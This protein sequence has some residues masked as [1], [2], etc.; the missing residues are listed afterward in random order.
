MTTQETIKLFERYVIANYARSPIVA[1]RGE[2]SYLWDAEGERYLD[3]FP[4]WGVNGIGHCHPRVVA[5]IR[6]Q[7]GKLLHVANVPFYIEQQGR[8][9]QLISERSFGGQCFFCN[10][11]AEANEAAI[12]LARR[13]ASDQVAKTGGPA[14]FKIITV[15]N[16]FHGRT[17]TTVA[18]TAQAKYHAGFYPLPPGFVHVPFD[19]VDVVAKVCDGETCAVLVE[20]IQGEGGV[21]IPSDDYLPRLREL[22]DARGILLILDEV[23]TGVGRTGKWFGHQHAGVEPDIMTLAKALGGGL[24]IGAMTARP[25]VARSLVPG[26]HA[27]T[28]G[29]NP[30]ACAAGIATFEAIEE[31]DLLANAQRIGEQVKS[32]MLALAEKLGLIREVRARGCMI[33]V[34]LDRPGAD[35]VARCTEN[36][37]LI[38]C[39]HGTVLRMLPSMAATEAEIGQ[40]LDILQRVLEAC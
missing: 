25:A 34:E 29:G 15:Y 10:S 21:N 38:N 8:L 40:G 28:F 1:V 20:P 18:A 7:A 17:L 24:A 30:I 13:Y 23:Q 32:R 31:E 12:K 33:G 27:S 5:A 6:E 39:T 37:L 14:R 26:T 16:S 11:G 35:I 3:L 36:G 2:G 4:G 9:A 19:D 22:C